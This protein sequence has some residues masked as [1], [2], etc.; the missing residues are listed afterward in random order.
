MV[1]RKEHS[2]LIKV[3]RGE[4]AANLILS[5][6]KVINTL[7]AQI[8]LADVA[9]H[10]DRIAGVGEYQEAEKVIDLEGKYLSPGFI[11]GHV[12][13]ES[14]MLNPGE[15]AKAIVPRG[16]L[17]IVTDFHEIANVCGLSGIEYFLQ[18]SSLLPMDIFGMA[19]SCVP[20][21]HFETSGAQL[22]VQDLKELLKK[23]E[24]IGLGEVMNYPGVISGDSDIMAKIEL[25]RDHIIDGHAP[26]LSGADL[27]AYIAAGIYSDHEC[28]KIEEAKEKLNKGMYIMI[29]E[30][31]SEKNLDDLL[32][33]VNDSSFKRC[34]FVDDD[35]NCYDI[36]K[37]GGVD[38]VIR[39]SIKKG[40][41]PM[42]AIQMATINTAEYFKLDDLGAIAPGYRANLVVLDDIEDIVASMVFYEGMHVAD[43]DNL[44]IKIP[45]VSNSKV[46]NTIRIKPFTEKKLKISARKDSESIIEIIP[47]QII[48]R[49][50][51]ER[52]KSKDG[53]YIA[54]LEKDI[55]KL[56]VVERHKAT[57]NIG[58]GFV[59]GFGLN[60][61]ALAT[62]IAHDSHNIIAV[63]TN[64][65]DMFVAIKELE[66]IQ[67]GLTIAQ[68]GQV[69]CSLALPIAGLLSE[70]HLLDVVKTKDEL[71]KKAL[72]LGCV[73]NAPFDTLSFL[74][75]PVI[76]E[77][78]LT[79][80]GMVD[81]GEF[82][83][84]E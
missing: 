43:N 51:D 19:P 65:H 42:R 56:A 13:L 4:K 70:N 2:E 68:N 26:G 47:D 60:K 33:L 45:T 84:I 25:F 52:I 39:K 23:Q 15:Y 75:L 64:D 40:L 34:L 6:A 21:T 54:D 81:V 1:I 72:D 57:G 63:G 78:R 48:T 14:S 59:R 55:L 69:L 36:L 71:K 20:A 77:L 9:I 3:A 28:S 82:K 8:E 44:R 74:A 37:E 18:Y 16:V 10:G 29:R 22:G 12:H 31:S 24:I 73:L 32:P 49:R 11:D 46:L 5:N 50:C 17:S 27:N 7:T 80:L 62:S 66:K 79:D 58:L 76:P 67:G 35:R 38:A 83:L 30:G 61:G 53:Y 41:D